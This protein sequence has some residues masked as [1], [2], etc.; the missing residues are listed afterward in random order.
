MITGIKTGERIVLA[1]R[2]EVCLMK[3]GHNPNE[4]TLLGKI[5]KVTFEGTFIRYEIHLENGDHFIINK[6]SL[7]E[8]WMNVG[9]DV[10]ISYPIDKAHV[11]MNPEGG[12]TQEIA[13]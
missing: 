1:L 2:P 11:F 3:K 7:T 5:E 8:E 6:P 10:T 9:D 13:V 4:N 12:L